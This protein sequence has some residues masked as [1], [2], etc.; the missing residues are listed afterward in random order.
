MSLIFNKQIQFSELQLSIL[1]SNITLMW[2]F[3]LGFEI[4]DVC[5][6]FG[7]CFVHMY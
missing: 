6:N 5:V 1:N 4:R 2:N 7:A 3:T